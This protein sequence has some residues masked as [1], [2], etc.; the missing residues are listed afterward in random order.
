[1]L[2]G[3]HR[4]AHT[5]RC[6][7]S[8]TLLTN[9]GAGHILLECTHADMKKQHIARHDAMMRMSV[10]EFAKGAKGSHYSSH[11]ENVG[12]MDT[13]KDIGVHSKR[14]PKFVLPDPLI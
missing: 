9:D 5:D 4:T 10:K 2:R 7:S 3:M 14:V 1:M 8:Q 11:D 13:L 12:T 6:F